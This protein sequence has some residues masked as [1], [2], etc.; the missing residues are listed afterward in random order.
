[1]RKS[2]KERWNVLIATSVLEGILRTEWRQLSL[3]NMVAGE[4]TR[5]LE[6]LG[7]ENDWSNKLS[8]LLYSADPL[9]TGT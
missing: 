2:R 9:V 7:Q 1:M 4:I 6:R 5:S 3:P 8:E